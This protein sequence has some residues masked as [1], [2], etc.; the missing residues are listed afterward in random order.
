[1]SSTYP[2]PVGTVQ[3]GFLLLEDAYWVRLSSVI[4]VQDVSTASREP[5]AKTMALEGMEA[6]LYLSGGAS[7]ATTLRGS[8]LRKVTETGEQLPVPV[9]RSPTDPVTGEYRKMA[10][11]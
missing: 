3:G 2:P 8:W 4:A 5:W 6:V 7:C 1:M 11:A 9:V 10:P